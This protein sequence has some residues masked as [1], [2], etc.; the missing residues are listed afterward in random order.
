MY[1]YMHMYT[2]ISTLMESLYMIKDGVSVRCLRLAYILTV[3]KTL[4]H[5]FLRVLILDWLTFL[6]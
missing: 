2:Y 4:R 3:F 5:G 1:V 6:I